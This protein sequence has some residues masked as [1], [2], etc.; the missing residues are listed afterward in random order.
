MALTNAPQLTT[1]RLELR[2]PVKADWPAI[3]AMVSHPR[4]TRFLG[5][6]ATSAEHFARFCRSAGSWLLYGYG[7]FTIRRRDLGQVI[8]NCGIFHTWRGLGPDFDDMPE[9]GWVLRH[10]QE[11]V[12]Y[13]HEAMR[14]VFEWF[15]SEHGPRRVVCMIAQRNVPSLRLARKLGFTPMREATL[16]GG[17]TVGLF[18]RLP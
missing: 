6:G 11:G 3:L 1:E 18:E 13:G 15:D 8:G 4:T 7:A 12:G 16:P 17:E 14:A 9:A 10:D 2:L 5:S